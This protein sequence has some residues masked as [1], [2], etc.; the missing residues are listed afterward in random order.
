MGITNKD[1]QTAKAR[2]EA[3][4]DVTRAEVLKF[5]REVMEHSVPDG[6][7]TVSDQLRAAEIILE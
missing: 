4:A 1:H 6:L 7:P 3:K 2:A 5:L